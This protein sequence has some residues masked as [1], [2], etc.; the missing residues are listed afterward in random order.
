L[1]KGA[2]RKK[3]KRLTLTLHIRYLRGQALPI[4]YHTDDGK[5][6]VQDGS[7]PRYNGGEQ[8]K[9][10]TNVQRWLTAGTVP[11]AKKHGIEQRL[12]TIIALDRAFSL[13]YYV[14]M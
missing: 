1:E 10:D 8:N 6:R 9:K 2:A 5:G 13:V 11:E 7:L 3:G 14:S 12:E 4:D